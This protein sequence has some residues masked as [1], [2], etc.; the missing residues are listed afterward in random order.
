MNDSIPAAE[1]MHEVKLR[2]SQPWSEMIDGDSRSQSSVASSDKEQSHQE[3]KDESTTQLA[4]TPD[5]SKG[6]NGSARTISGSSTTPTFVDNE[7]DDVTKATK[8]ISLNEE[9]FR[10][11]KTSKGS[12]SV[13]RNPPNNLP[14]DNA[15]KGKVS[16]LKEAIVS[17]S[18]YSSSSKGRRHTSGTNTNETSANPGKTF[19]L[20]RNVSNSSILPSSTAS[21]SNA[22]TRVVSD[23]Q[24]DA[25]LAKKTNRSHV[26]K[27]LTDEAKAQ[28]VAQLEPKA[29]KPKPKSC[30]ESLLLEKGVQGNNLIITLR[31]KR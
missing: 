17:E 22:G 31:Y 8:K 24:N 4:L 21:D 29:L 2:V 18:S 27:S 5:N 23:V 14:D 19:E 30:R 10:L 16:Y 26:R 7:V 9:K 6:G 25:E 3:R 13:A 1:N 11:F 15:M 20:T 12:S 28:L